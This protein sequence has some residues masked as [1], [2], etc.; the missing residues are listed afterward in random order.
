[1]KKLKKNNNKW[2]DKKYIDSFIII[3]EVSENK[4]LSNYSSFV[5][6]KNEGYSYNN[7]KFKTLWIW[8]N[9]KWRFKI[10][11]YES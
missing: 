10:L 3:E 1:M 8:V 9:K 7:F 6:S 2:Y 5:N 11:K 4:D